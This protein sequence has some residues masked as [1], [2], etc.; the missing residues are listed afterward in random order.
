VPPTL[1]QR[2]RAIS[3]RLAPE[4]LFADYRQILHMNTLWPGN[5]NWTAFEI[6][7]AVTAQR[8]VNLGV[9][10]IETMDPASFISQRWP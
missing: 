8:L 1:G 4:L 10:Y 7:D 2:Y 6:E 3:E 9:R 5:W